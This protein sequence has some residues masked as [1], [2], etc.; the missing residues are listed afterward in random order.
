MDPLENIVD[1]Q[2]IAS[3]AGG[4]ENLFQSLEKAV[5]IEDMQWALQLSDYLINLE[6]RIN[7]TNILRKEALFH[8]GTRASNPNKRNYLLFI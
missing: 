2:I 1:S 8:I 3:L 5:A 6:F 7:E 4:N